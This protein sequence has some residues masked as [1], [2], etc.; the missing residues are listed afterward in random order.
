[1]RLALR[2]IF[3]VV[4]LNDR[5]CGDCGFIRGWPSCVPTPGLRDSF[6]AL[7][8]IGGS[9][10][11]SCAR[12]CR[13]HVPR[14]LGR[15]AGLRGGDEVVS[16]SGGPGRRR[17][18]MSPRFHVRSR[19]RRTA[20]PRRGCDMVPQSGGSRFFP[21]AVQPRRHVRGRKRRAAGLR[22]GDEVVPQSGGSGRS[23]CE[24]QSRL[25]YDHGQG[26]PQDHAE[27]AKWYR[28]AADQGYATA[29]GIL[30]STY[31]YGRGV[32]QNYVLAHMWFNLAAAKGDGDSLKNR[33]LVA[34]E[35]TPIDIAEA[36]RLARE[37]KPKQ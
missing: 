33:D 26:V 22:R 11:H 4:F 3:I 15:C 35:M 12:W 2:S 17:G 29:Q 7:A 14:R 36:Q 16:Q 8:A 30:G 6:A 10:Q 32:P 23:L 21:G 34:S 25:I 5:R 20:G 27:A 28:K 24:I 13:F 9:G 37:W 18:A 1:M 19:A 31:Y